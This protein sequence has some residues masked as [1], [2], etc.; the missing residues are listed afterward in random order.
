[1]LLRS[2][3]IVTNGRISFFL[4]LNNIP[5]YVNTL[6]NIHSSTDEQLSYFHVL[7]SVN[8]AATNVGVQISLQ[9][10]AQQGFL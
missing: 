10:R 7:A 8:N 6:K 5:L 9:D 3:C 4:R 2:I 1:M